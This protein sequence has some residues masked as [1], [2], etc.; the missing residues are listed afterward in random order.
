MTRTL[1]LVL[2]LAALVALALAAP[3]LAAY[4][5]R[6]VVSSGAA[7]TTINFRQAP[8]DDPTAK[9][10]IFAASGLTANLSAA[11]GTT[12]GSVDAQAAAADLGGA[13]LPLGGTVQVRAA[14][15]TY[16]SS[17][18]QVPIAA[19]ATA[20]TGT[21]AHG[22]FWVLILTAAG[23]TLELPLF[24]DAIPT[25][26][27][28]AAFSVAVIQVCLS[29]PDVP[30]G[31]PGRATF[32]AKVLQA[33]FTVKGIFSSGAGEFR[34][35]TA[36]T[37]YTPGAGKANAAGTAET[38]SLVRTPS[39]VS[40]A[41]RK[42]KI[43][44]RAA[45]SGAVTENGQPVAG[46]AVQILVGKRVVGAARTNASG[47]FAQTVRLPAARARL[48]ARAVVA[49]RDLGASAC[50]ATFSPVPCIGATV[51]GFTALSRTVAVST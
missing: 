40:L 47:R 20:C 39:T 42:T 28:R 27:P 29:P 10:Q 43:T 21:A 7:G 34:W 15:G 49:A 18:A 24:I 14:A 22:A 2:P 33:V 45:V 51:G 48:Q 8:A 6:L 30:A 31:T 17:G 4:A 23:Q 1:R 35:R 25:G 9:L 5:P 26:D 16:L 50:T 13:I 11:V 19:A 37:P 3:A 36:A 46:A 41:A 32:G 44:K 12:I 38:Q